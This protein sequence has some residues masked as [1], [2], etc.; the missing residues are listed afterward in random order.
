LKKLD[1]VLGNFKFNDAFR[2][3][4]AVFYPYR[5]SDH[6][7]AIL[8][9]P[10]SVKSK[11]K[12]FKFSNILTQHARFKE[13]V[14]GVWTTNVSGFSM[15]KVVKK[16]KCLKKP[17]RIL[18]YEHGNLHLNVDH[19]CKELDQV[20][21]ELDS[22]PSNVHLRDKEVAYVIAYN[23]VLLLQERFLKQQAKVQWLKEG[24]ANSA[25]FHKA[26]KS[27]NLNLQNIFGVTLDEP[28][29]LEMVQN[30]SSRE[31]KEAMFSMGND[32]SPG[33]DGFTA[34]F[35]KEAW[36]I[37]GNDVVKAV[38][39]FFTNGN[40]LKELNHTVIALILKIKNPSR[41]NDYRP[42]SCCNVLFK[43]L[44]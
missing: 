28:T 37:V 7:P 4:H 26:V 18:L 14:N 6:S 44:S 41:V 25:Y 8:K 2:D 38:G 24:D 3:A 10:G 27:R 21:T 5:T 30:V 15:Y 11:P 43:C 33:P 17:F 22:D 9:I 19:L 40:L 36:D 29:A 34:A 16:L 12:P 23:E 42:I 39:E 32:K 31:V 1:R 13:V 35:F 20:Q